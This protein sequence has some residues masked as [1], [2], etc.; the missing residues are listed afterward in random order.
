MEN[1]FFR[2]GFSA[3]KEAIFFFIRFMAGLR[4]RQL[5][6]LLPY[7][8]V[9]YA[10]TFNAHFPGHRTRRCPIANGEKIASDSVLGEFR[11]K[12]ISVHAWMV[13]S[14]SSLPAWEAAACNLSAP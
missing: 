11:M 4:L 13:A 14:S 3:V 12:I 8:L 7:E 1:D 5:C 10:E 9:Y 6:L 2:E